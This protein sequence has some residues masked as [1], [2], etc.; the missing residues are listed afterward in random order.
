MLLCGLCD[1]G[2][3]TLLCTLATG[4][5]P[6]TTTSLQH[7]VLSLPLSAQ[8]LQGTVTLVDVPG[9]PRIRGSSL[10]QFQELTAAIAFLVDAVQFPNNS[11]LVADYL[12]EVLIHPVFKERRVPVLVVC[13]KFDIITASPINKIKSTLESEL[14]VFL[15]L[16]LS[17]SS[18]FSNLFFFLLGKRF[19]RPE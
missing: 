11:R 4:A 7:S 12:Y 6:K 19:E 18:L 8:G 1:A 5:S 10:Q 3:T 15:I 2:K 13:N 17:C 16:F 14:Y 9:H